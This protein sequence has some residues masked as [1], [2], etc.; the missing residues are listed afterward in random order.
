MYALHLD[1]RPV[2]QRCNFTAG[3]GSF[4][5]KPAFDEEYARFS[6][7]LLL[8][9]ETIRRL[10]AKPQIRWMDSCT[11]PDNRMMNGIWTDRRVIQ[12]TLV[13]THKRLGGLT[14]SVIPL[15]R[16]LKKNLPFRGR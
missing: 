7:G 9:L 16:W 15:V 8:E 2:A 11:T 6:P 3:E 12:T 14:V 1:G 10:H 13:A 4:F 5:F